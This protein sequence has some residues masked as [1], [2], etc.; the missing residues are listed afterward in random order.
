MLTLGLLL[1]F[2]G[3]VLPPLATWSLFILILGYL[4]LVL[5]V[6]PAAAYFYSRARYHSSQGVGRYLAG[7]AVVGVPIGLVIGIL[8]LLLALVE[9]G[10]AS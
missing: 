8:F 9:G 2:A 5:V 4:P 6:C 10:A 1:T 3:S 7:S